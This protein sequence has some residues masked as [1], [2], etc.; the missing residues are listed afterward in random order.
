MQTWYSRLEEAGRFARDVQNAYV[1]EFGRKIFSVSE[2][3]V[4]CTDRLAF[5][6][7]RFLSKEID[8]ENGLTI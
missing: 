6:G 7:L 2:R 1:R 8:H 3:W 4:I 5:E